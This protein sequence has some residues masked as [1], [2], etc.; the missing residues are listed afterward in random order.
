[1][2]VA[3]VIYQEVCSPDCQENTKLCTCS[4]VSGLPDPSSCGKHRLWW[5]VAAGEHC[6]R[7]ARLLSR[8]HP[9]LM[10]CFSFLSPPYRFAVNMGIPSMASLL[11]TIQGLLSCC[12]LL[13]A[14]RLQVKQVVDHP[15][16]SHL[17]HTSHDST[18]S[19]FAV[20][21]VC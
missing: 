2:V 16:T 17:N 1:M 13:E 3:V 19:T 11:D 10:L 4:A 8:D 21:T 6:T 18:D 9:A 15:L 7:T 14:G 12:M 5:F 20:R